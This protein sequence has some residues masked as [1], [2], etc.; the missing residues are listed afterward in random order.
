MTKKQRIYLLLLLLIILLALAYY[1]FYQRGHQQGITT[2]TELNVD[3][4]SNLNQS[5]GQN[6]VASEEELNEAITDQAKQGQ[7]IYSYR[8]T[9]RDPFAGQGLVKVNTLTVIPAQAQLNEKRLVAMVPFQIE[10]IIGNEQQR[11]AII[12]VNN[13][14]RII[15]TGDVVDEFEVIAIKEAGFIMSY[16]GIIFNLGLRGVLDER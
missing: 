3:S 15:R 1:Y 10:G 16:Q 5:P 2:L 14:S 4:D 13:Q 6:A 11:V 8:N 9:F 12:A 7:G